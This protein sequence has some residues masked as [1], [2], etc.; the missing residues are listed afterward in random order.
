MR[1]PFRICIFVFLCTSPISI[2]RGQAPDSTSTAFEISDAV[3]IALTRSNERRRQDALLEQHQAKRI[4]AG[5][6]PNPSV[7]YTHEELR[8]SGIRYS[9]WTATADYP[10]LSLLVR[11]NRIDAADLNVRAAAA[12]KTRAIAEL[13][14]DVRRQF[15]SVWRLR[16]VHRVLRETEPRILTL[17]QAISA[18]EEEGEISSYERHRLQTELAAIQWRLTTSSEELRSA[19]TMLAGLLNMPLDS[20][21]SRVFILPQAYNADFDL[22]IL[23]NTGYEHRSDLEAMRAKRSALKYKNSWLKK[24]W[25]EDIRIGGGYKSQSNAFSGPVLTVSTPIPLFERNQGPVAENDAAQTMLN[26]DLRSLERQVESEIRNAVSAYVQVQSLAASIQFSEKSG[27]ADLI[28]TA[29]EAYL[30]GEF[31]LVEYLDALTAYIDGTELDL[32]IRTAVLLAAY[33]LEH[34]VERNIFS[35]QQ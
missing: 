3:N 9:E 20:L 19:E 33:R 27:R 12:M 16:A 6:L 34:A 7:S 30:E 10:F 22:S 5:T 17:D 23:L 24:A 18:R 21:T 2:A 15:L 14:F 29:S 11:G 26:A 28:T 1:L 13:A 35:T 25:M 31:S 4:A 32:T 8:G